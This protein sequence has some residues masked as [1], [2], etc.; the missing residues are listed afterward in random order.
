MWPATGP[1]QIGL[2]R[3]DADHRV[4]IASFGGQLL[5]HLVPFISPNMTPRCRAL[6]EHAHQPPPTSASG[7]KSAS[8]V[9]RTGASRRQRPLARLESRALSSLAA[10]PRPL[11]SA[12]Y[13]SGSCGCR[14]QTCR[15]AAGRS[16]GSG[17]APGSAG[18]ARR[19][20]GRP[21]QA[22]LPLSRGVCRSRS[23]RRSLQSAAKP[24]RSDLPFAL[25][26]SSSIDSGWPSSAAR[27]PGRPGSAAK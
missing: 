5:A 25:A 21:A 17:D 16:A 12:R 13:R 15:P 23:A 22:R 24:L 26:A 4:E 14:P 18:R 2:P 10:A 1:R 6:K 20:K 27:R 19:A 7:G 8:S 3:R 11:W 9:S